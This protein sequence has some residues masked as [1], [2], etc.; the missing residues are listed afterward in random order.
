MV[1]HVKLQCKRKK[2]KSTK[3]HFQFIMLKN[4]TDLTC[5]VTSNGQQQLLYLTGNH[6]DS[7]LREI[8]EK[9]DFN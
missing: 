9:I 2:Q 8:D 1:A 6:S 5:S 4:C 7:E 3:L